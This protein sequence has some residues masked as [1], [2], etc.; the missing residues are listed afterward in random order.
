MPNSGKAILQQ[1]GNAQ[2]WAKLALDTGI[3]MALLYLF[4]LERTGSFGMPYQVM[5]LIGVLLMVT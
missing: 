2:I 5:A 1:Y 4:V 3:A